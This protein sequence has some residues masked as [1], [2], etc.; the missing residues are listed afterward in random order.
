MAAEKRKIMEN[1]T[2]RIVSWAVFLTPSQKILMV[3]FCFVLMGAGFYFFLF[4][5]RLERLEKNRK[6][7]TFQQSLL[8]AYQE[9]AMEFEELTRQ[10]QT[11]NHQFL[12]AA[13]AL[14][15]KRQSARLLEAF[16]HAG[17]VAQVNLLSLREET[18]TSLD[19]CKKIPWTIQATG[20]YVQLVNFL[21][22]IASMDRIV[23]IEGMQMKRDKEDSLIHMDCTAVTYREP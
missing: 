23:T 7:L 22:H 15:H 17:Q 6:N 5:D 4:Q 18:E 11:K 9:K 21:F 19:F 10:I 20:S 3:L 8:C 14:P 2:D 16:S 13:A 1:I 12:T